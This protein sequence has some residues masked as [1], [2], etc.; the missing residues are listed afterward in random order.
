VIDV[1]FLLSRKIHFSD[2]IYESVAVEYGIVSDAELIPSFR[3]GHLD[4]LDAIKFV[5]MSRAQYVPLAIPNPNKYLFTNTIERMKNGHYDGRLLNDVIHGVSKN[6]GERYTLFQSIMTTNASTRILSKDN[7]YLLP[8][9]KRCEI[10]PYDPQ[11][12]MYDKIFRDH[13]TKD[14]TRPPRTREDVICLF[15]SSGRPIDSDHGVDI[16]ITCL[17]CRNLL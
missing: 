1:I 15:E 9:F 14:G 11:C 3:C 10:D 13:M 5:I 6:L 7:Q 4:G 8:Y 2:D 12:S 17:V 16:A